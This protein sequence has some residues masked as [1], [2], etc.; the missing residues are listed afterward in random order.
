M[1]HLTPTRRRA[2]GAG[3]GVLLLAASGCGNT[4]LDHD[5]DPSLLK[6]NCAPGLTACAGLCQSCSAPANAVPACVAGACG[7]ECDSGYN[8]CSADACI[9]ESATSCGAACANC[10]A[11]VLPPDASAICSSA[12]VCDFVCSPGFLRSGSSCA[13]AI[14]VSAGFVHTCALTADGSVKC[15]GANDA[16]QLGNGTASDSLAPVDVTLPGRATILAAG[17]EHTCAVVGGV[18]YCW[19]DNTFGEIGDGTTTTRL[20][21]V[22]VTGLPP[23]VALGAGGGILAHTSFGHTCAVD[24]QGAVKCWGANGSGQLGD[25][26]TTVRTSPVPVTILPSGTSVGQVACG[27]RHT[28]VVAAGGA[29]YCFGANDSGQLGIGTAAAQMAPA[30]T[31]LASGASAVFTGQAHSC[32]LAGGLLCWG[33]NNSGQV[34]PGAT[35]TGSFLS[36][37]P[38]GLGPLAPTAVATGRAHTCAVDASASP[39]VPR[40]FG[41]NDA[42]QLGGVANPPA[43]PV[44]VPLL[45]PATAQ[46]MTAGSDHTCLLTREGGIQCWGANDRGQLGIASP[47]TSSPPAYVSGR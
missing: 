8:R 20:S 26:S 33:N 3:L 17:Y 2:L 40:C 5:A 41:Q 18:V 28:C 23:T 37:T 10:S 31:T 30:T 22:P 7:F 46:A 21:P 29:V 16:G 44:A 4:L 15:W 32:A 35:T 9:A 13:R 39:A 12:H 38:P 45:P 47:S 25:G 24:G 11:A 34:D 27:E 43:G 6:L 42:G 14:A 36:P 19:G 1:E